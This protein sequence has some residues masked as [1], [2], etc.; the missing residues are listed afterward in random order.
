M[1]RFLQTADFILNPKDSDIYI[2]FL[3]GKQAK[4][5]QKPC[6]DLNKVGDRNACLAGLRHESV[7]FHDLGLW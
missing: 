4:L 1:A 5:S 2:L 3:K 7:Q 6:F